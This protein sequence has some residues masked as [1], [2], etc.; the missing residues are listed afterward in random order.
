LIVR[1]FIALALLPSAWAQTPQFEAASI[2]VNP[3]Q[4]GFHFAAD[5]ATGGP[6]S[7]DPG[8]FRCSKCTL[9]T[10]IAKAFELRSY[11]FP[12]RASLG[13]NTFDVQAKVPDGASREDFQ[14][15]LQNLLK[16]RFGLA[17][18]FKDK[19]LRGYRLVIAGSGSKLQESGDKTGPAPAEG[20]H[21]FGPPGQTEAHSHSGPMTFGASSMFRAQRQTMADLALIISDQ[22]SLPVDDRTGLNGVYDISLNW[23]SDSTGPGNHA[24]SGGHADYSAGHGDHGIAAPAGA[25]GSTEPSG[26]TLFE[27]LQSQLGLKLVASEQTTA[28]I[29]AIDHIERAPTSN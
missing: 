22:L 13:D 26:P 4:S 19:P 21:R 3:P 24:E 6:G 11:Q 5:S 29:L 8:L 25:A 23:S 2:K 15:M 28:R 27:A 14:A 12:E 10:L 18:H 17:Y 7:A 16:E 1:W 20:A 9:S